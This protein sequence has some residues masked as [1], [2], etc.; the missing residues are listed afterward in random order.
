[1]RILK[2]FIPGRFEDA[3]AYRGHLVTLTENGTLRLYDLGRIAERI[4]E[5]FPQVAP[6]ATLL[7]ARNDWLASEQFRSLM[8]NQS[9]ARAVLSTMRQFPQPFVPIDRLAT[10][11]L[12]EED[13]KITT[14]MFLDMSIYNNRLYLGADNGLY[15]VDL[16]WSSPSVTLRHRPTKRIDAKCLH[17]LTGYGT[18]S[19]SCG[20]DGL[21][22]FIN[23]FGQFDGH[24][25]AAIERTVPGRS[26]RSSWLNYNIMNY[27]T[28][29][30]PLLFRTTRE[31]TASIGVERERT[32]LVDIN[33]RPL[34]LDYMFDSICSEYHV[35]AES[36]QFAYNSNNAMFVNT[37]DGHLFSIFFRSNQEEDPAVTVT[38]AYPGTGTRILSAHW[39]RPG[40]V[41][42]TDKSVLLFAHGRLFPI[43]EAEALSVRTFPRSLRFKNLVAITLEDGILL[44][45]L[46]DDERLQVRDVETVLP[47]QLVEG[48]RMAGVQ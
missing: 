47:H 4:D 27:S 8:S 16:D 2:L 37:F 20:D 42:E 14:D 33:S 44:A 39:T 22:T 17:T 36:I 9:V 34:S 24:T 23:E 43:T 31:R 25:Q 6:V 13:L 40:A 26:L 15:H 10:D 19:A 18:V 41:I 30:T 12:E 5:Q 38:R 48:D 3:Y 35:E 1:M 46:F 28:P 21:H 29:A 7:F 32:A 11:E 45:G